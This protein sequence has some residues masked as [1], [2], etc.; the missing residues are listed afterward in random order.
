MKATCTKAKR[1]QNYMVLFL[2]LFFTSFMSYKGYTGLPRGAV[3]VIVYI[4]MI[5]LMTN[6]AY[7]KGKMMGRMVNLTI[8]SFLLSCIPSVIVFGQSIYEA[9]TGIQMYIFPMLLYYVL[10]KWRIDE[11]VIFKYLV[12]FTAAFG[13]FEVIQ[14]YTY[15][16]FWFNGREANEFTGLLEE[17][18]GFWRFYLFGIDYCILSIMLCFGKILKKE[19]KQSHNYLI[20]LVC[21]VAIF[22]PCSKGYLCSS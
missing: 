18:M 5:V 9:I 8:V 12:A 17:R 22:L 16:V 3:F 21:A 20:F 2:M 11:K 19:G 14:Q 13:F 10:H 7:L 1:W 6:Q 4:A 15:P